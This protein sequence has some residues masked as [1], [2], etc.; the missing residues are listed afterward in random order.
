MATLAMFISYEE[1][2]D[3]F[4]INHPEAG[5]LDLPAEYYQLDID[6]E[7]SH[8]AVGKIKELSDAAETFVYGIG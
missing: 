4:K 7:S 5:I 8:E 1:S 3:T 6:E 2:N